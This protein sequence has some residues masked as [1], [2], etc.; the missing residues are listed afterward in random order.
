MFTL[1]KKNNLLVSKLNRFAHLIIKHSRI[2]FI[3]W[4]IFITLLTLLPGQAIPNISW[5]FISIDKTVHIVMFSTLVFIGLLGVQYNGF[6][7]GRLPKLTIMLG[8]I[9]YGY[10]LELLQSYIPQRSY[11][12]ADLAADSVGTLVGY[13]L[14]LGMTIIL[15]KTR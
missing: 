6:K 10:I 11:D 14:F 13:G 8:A 9:L 1:I 7:L 3:G 15:S 4:I 12:F 2:L 5:D